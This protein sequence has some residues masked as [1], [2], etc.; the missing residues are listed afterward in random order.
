M[1]LYLYYIFY[2]NMSINVREHRRG[3]Q[4]W[5]IQNKWQ[6]MVYKTRDEDKQSKHTAQYVLDNTTRNLTQIT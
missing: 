3:N 2:S 4:K 1:N 5:T 6:H